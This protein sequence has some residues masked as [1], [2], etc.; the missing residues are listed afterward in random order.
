MT[1]RE[2]EGVVPAD[3]DGG[4]KPWSLADLVA[5]LGCAVAGMALAILPHLVMLAR[6]GTPEFL[7]DGDEVAYLI[8]SRPPYYGEP[9]LRDPFSGI[10]EHSP[11]Y[12]PWMLFVPLAK[13]GRLLGVPLILLGML[14]RTVGGLLFGWSLFFLFRRICAGLRRPTAWAAGCAIA[15]LSDAGFIS[16]RMLV[17]GPL[18]A[19]AA[20]QGVKSDALAQ[21]RVVNPLLNL[22]FLI[23]LVGAFLGARSAR[24]RSLAIGVTSLALCIWLNFYVWTSAVAGLSLFC[25]FCAAGWAAGRMKG[26]GGGK[27]DASRLAFAVLVLAGGLAV[28]GAQIYSNSRTFSDPKYREI[29][30]RG[31]KGVPLEAGDPARLMNLR[32]SW[33]IAKLALGA[34]GILLLR[35]RRLAVLWCLTFAGF[36]LANSAIITGREFENFQF[37]YVHS[38][39]GEVLLVGLA[40]CALGRREWRP[41]ARMALGAVPACLLAIGAVLRADSALHYRETVAIAGLLGELR[42]LG[43]ALSVVGEDSSLAGPPEAAVALLFTRSAML[44]HQPYTWN[45]C[46]VSDETVHSRHALNGWLRGMDRASYAEAAAKDRNVIFPL[47]GHG[48]EEVARRRLRIF[49][50]IEKGGGGELMGRFRPDYLLLRASAPPPSREG[51]WRLVRRAPSW[52]LWT[53]R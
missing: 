53:R 30:A 14:W 37:R 29:M 18:S 33:A 21:F 34:A 17:Q 8:V 44:Y 35:E 49:D 20:A 31:T 42:P 4:A 26:P 52:T 7:H 32:D 41:W 38:P 45:M 27:P 51:P 46:M 5:C 11:T 2:P 36:A 15:C 24:R 9:G 6:D 47:P 12:Y 13:L 3:P 25:L 19:W 48:P 16:G 10:W 28:G 43:G 1:E 22:P 23:F 50:G 40:A 39:M